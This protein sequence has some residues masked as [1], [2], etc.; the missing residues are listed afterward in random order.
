MSR[1]LRVLLIEDADDDAVLIERELRQRGFDPRLHRVQDEA[2]MADALEQSDWDVVISDYT[3]PR[4][5]APAALRLLQEKGIDL[6]FLIAS[7]TI[8][9]EAAVGALRAGAHD[10]VV[11]SN[12]ARLA[13][14]IERAIGDAAVRGERRRMEAELRA[15]A[16]LVRVVFEQSPVAIAATDAAAR[17]T[18][19]NPAAERIFGWTA[20]EVI[21][22]S[23]REAPEQSDL[24]RSVEAALRGQRLTDLQMERPA[25]DGHRLNL[26]VSAAP[27]H[28]E[29]GIAG[30]VVVAVDVTA[31]HSLEEQYR[32]AQK[33]EAVGRLAGGIAHDFN[34]LL[35][36]IT[37]YSDLLLGELPADS[38]L[39]PDVA[40]IRNAATRATNLTRQLL[41]FS[42]KQVLRPEPLDLNTLIT[43]TENLLRRVMPEDTQFETRLAPVLPQVVADAGQIEQILMN[44]VVNARDAMPAG[45][46][47][48]IST[49]VAPRLPGGEQ[50]RNG[51]YVVV[52]VSD[53]G[54]GMDAATRE[55]IFEPFFTTKGPG[56]GT[57]LGLA[58]VY[59]IVQQSS[60]HIEVRSTLGKGTVFE[61][62]FPAATA[63]AASARHGR[64]ADAPSTS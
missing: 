55:R 34:N 7:G 3:L 28:G 12:L 14:A 4:F 43:N 53:T 25:K 22:S 29:E 13:P 19:W 37:G 36:A 15:S 60:G 11:K 20:P 52:S 6:P 2:S 62:Y 8:T 1:P 39:R 42:R 63:G 10:F 50:A 44:L 48:A 27:L 47:V 5:D 41:A 18:M 58:T 57:G 21:G 59:G 31:H 49:F 40:E 24:A 46:Q 9:E 16:E 35:T 51:G 56:K 45:G 30:A 64:I 17:L 33:M 54:M 38:S 32:H 26:S 61:I 23:L